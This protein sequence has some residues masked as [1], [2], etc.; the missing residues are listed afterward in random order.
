MPREA[1]TPRPALFSESNTRFLCEI[2][3]GRGR[4]FEAA[5]ADIPHA[6]IGQVTDGGKLEIL[7]GNAP[8]RFTA[9]IAALKEAWQKPLRW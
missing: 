6:R 8:G 5:L 4:G 7:S 1:L 3:P 2:R 9:D